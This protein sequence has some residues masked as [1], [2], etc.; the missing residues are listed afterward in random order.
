MEEKD[1]VIIGG[2]PAGYVAAI[3][4]AQLGGKVSLIEKDALGG[5]CLNRG[6]VPS[7]SLLHSVELF[8]SMKSAEQYGIKATD[9]SIDLAKMQANKNKIVSTLVAG[10]QSLLVGN[11]VEVIKGRAKLTPSRQVEIDTGRNRSRR[12]RQRR[13]FWPLAV[14]Q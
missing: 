13:S 1:I 6:C 4:A 2:G 3:R 14:N 8:Q 5:T 12:F 9:V 11:K 7:K 10:V